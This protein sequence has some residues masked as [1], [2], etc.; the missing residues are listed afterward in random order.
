[1]KPNTE[2]CAKN[3][4]D[5]KGPITTALTS[6]NAVSHNT[7]M[8]IEITKKTTP[9]EIRDWVIK[10]ETLVEQKKQRVRDE[11]TNKVNDLL[12]ENEYT[13]EELLG[14]RIL[15]SASDLAELAKKNR[16]AARQRAGKMAESS[17]AA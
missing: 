5:N 7:E 2:T 10:L 16:D 13:V 1:M 3:G 17:Y 12:A 4:N 11:L 8:T 14:A 6:N 15:P 9:K